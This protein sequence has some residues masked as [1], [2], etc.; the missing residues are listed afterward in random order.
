MKRLSLLELCCAVVALTAV[1]N[2]CDKLVASQEAE[3]EVAVEPVTFRHADDVLAGVLFRPTGSWPHAGIVLVT[4]S[5]A[6]DQT[7][8]G[9]ATALGKYFAARGLCC[10]SWDKPGVGS[11][12]GDFNRQTFPDRAAEALAAVRFLKQQTGMNGRPVGIWGHSQGGMVAPVAAS[13]SDDV[14]FLIVVAAWQGEA[15]RQDLVRVEQEM[16][17]DH[18]S[19]E[20]IA[21][22]VRFARRRMD[23]IRG[24]SPFE[25][26]DVAQEEV[27]SRPWFRYLHR[28]DRALFDSARKMVGYDNSADWEGVK[29]PVLAIYGGKDVSAGP[30]NPLL[31]I[32]RRGLENGGDDR[33]AVKIFSNARHDFCVPRREGE[34]RDGSPNFEPGYLEAMREWLSEVFGD[35]AKPTCGAKVDG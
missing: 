5:G 2:S 22:A 9:V 29:C 21:E 11:S 8:G 4:G 12:T 1:M 24:G 13:L 7:Y 23:L 25:V 35:T 3:A 31:A 14:G 17:A 15:W 19:Q 26:F 34:E 27:E 28:C 20:E 6:N 32:I 16:R 33:L 18:A 30:P 10:L